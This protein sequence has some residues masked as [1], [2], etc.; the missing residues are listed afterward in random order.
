M[1]LGWLKDWLMA[2]YPEWAQIIEKLIAD[3]NDPT[4]SNSASRKAAIKACEG[5][6]CAPDL[7]RDG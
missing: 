3:L 6:G 2:K 4:K 7:K 5:V 1:L